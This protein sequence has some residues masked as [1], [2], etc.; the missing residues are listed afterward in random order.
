MCDNQEL[1]LTA[2]TTSVA[3]QLKAYIMLRMKREVILVPL[4]ALFL[5]LLVL[6]LRTL[7][8]KREVILSLFVL[9]FLLLLMLRTRAQVMKGRPV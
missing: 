4:L 3:A 1:T 7:G 5:L 2:K 9:L 8:R 6:R